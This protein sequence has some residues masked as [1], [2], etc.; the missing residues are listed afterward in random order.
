[1][2]TAQSTTS[3]PLQQ[4]P[5]REDHPTISI[6]LPEV[7]MMVFSR[8]MRGDS[9]LLSELGLSNAD[10]HRLQ[11]LPSLALPRLLERAAHGDIT[12]IRFHRQALNSLLRHLKTDHRTEREVRTMIEA[13][14]S[15][16]FMK[17]FYAMPY[18][19]YHQYRQQAG[20][21]R[22][23]G[24]PTTPD[25]SAMNTVTVLL[26]KLDL[27]GPDATVGPF[28]LL[29]IHQ[30]TG[31]TLRDIWSVYRRASTEDVLPNK[32]IDRRKKL[33]DMLERLAAAHGIDLS[34][35]YSTIEA[36]RLLH[37]SQTTLH[38]RRE[39]KE[40]S[41][42]PIT[43]RRFEYLGIHLVEHMERRLCHAINNTTASETGI[44][45]NDQSQK[46]GTASASNPQ[47]DARNQL[48]SAQRTMKKLRP[49]SKT[50]TANH[51]V[52]PTPAATK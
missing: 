23:A 14:A 51:T 41:Y 45:D 37:I 6:P 38:R 30:L 25:T 15:H 20:L 3:A 5:S 33:N 47:P 44:S 31:H 2:H 7:A 12:E 49:R 40:I 29:A 52:Q 42:I 27:L 16:P 18:T 34:K 32:T 43:T 46:S 9:R 11:T 21:L 13:E 8:L 28:D 4:Q 10:L 1:M 48:A 26:H 35:S 24:R 39:A 36:A 22:P 50:G 19:V 17:H